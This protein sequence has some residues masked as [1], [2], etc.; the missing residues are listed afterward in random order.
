MKVFNILSCDDEED[1]L[2]SNLRNVVTIF[3]DEFPLLGA[4]FDAENVRIKLI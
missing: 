2:K 3:N 4:P 1:L